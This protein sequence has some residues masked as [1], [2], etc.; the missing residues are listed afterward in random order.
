M[1][2][3]VLHLDLHLPFAQSLKDKRSILKSLK[4]QLHGK[5]HVAVAEDDP[6]VKWQRASLGVASLGADRVTV[7]RCLQQ[8]IALLETHRFVEMILVEQEWR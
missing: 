2:V 8:I 1:I 4:D 3:G 6:N 5:F 7:E